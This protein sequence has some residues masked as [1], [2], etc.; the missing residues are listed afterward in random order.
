MGHGL[1]HAFFGDGLT[2]E[3][4]RCTALSH[5]KDAVGP[6]DDLFE[7]RRDH[8]HCQAFVRQRAD[9]PLDFPFSP[10]VYAAGRFPGFLTPC[11]R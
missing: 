6:F 11:V 3:F 1:E 9:Q 8:E 10:H 5:H 4:C 7:F 2:I